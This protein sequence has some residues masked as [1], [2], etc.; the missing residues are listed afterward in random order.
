MTPDGIVVVGGGIAGHS[1][2]EAIRERDADIPLTL[3]CGEPRLPYDRV[4][5]SELLVSGR[6]SDSLELRPVDWYEDHSVR[7]VLGRGATQIETSR[8]RV[9]LT[10]GEILPYDSLVVAT[11]SQ[12]LMPP[13]PGLHLPGVVSFRGPSDCEAIRG[14]AAAG[15]GRVAVIGGGLL[16]LEAAYGVASQGCPV[17]VIHLMDRLMERQLDDAAA[18]LLRPAMER[19]GV[20]VLLERETERVLGDER[21]RGLRFVDGSE[22]EAGLIVV[23]IG[24]HP[25]TSVAR[26]AGIEVA[27]GITVDDEMRTSAPSVWAV[28]ECAEHRGVVY[29][30]VA[31][32]RE[33]AEAAADSIVG[34]Q[35]RHAYQGSLQWAR[36]KVMGV[37]VVSIGRPEGAVQAVTTDASGP[38][39][40]KL[41]V[42]D[43]RA[44]GAIL[45]GDVRG[46]DDLLEAIRGAEQIVDPLP[47][48]AAAAEVTAAELPDGAQ[49]CNCN[50]VRK[51]DVLSA[52]RDLGCATAR[53]VMARTRAGTG[54]GS[55]KATVKELVCA[56]TG[57]VAE[58]PTY[59]CPCRRQTR[60]QLA[61][62]IREHELTAVSE[63]AAG[64]GTG[65]EC[66]TCKPALAYLVSEINANRHREQRE[67]RFINDRVH[68][69]IQKD[70]TFSVVPRMYGGVTT[71]DQLRRIADAAER[72]GA[73]MVK[74]TGGQRIDLLGVRKRDLPDIWRD[75]GMP[76]GHAYA[77]AV[78]TVKSCVGSDFCRFGLADSI[79]LAVALEKEWEGL[80]TPAKVKSGVSGC[81][82]NCAEATVK[83]IGVVAVEG[84]WQIRV[85]GAAGATVREAD[86]LACVQSV[87]EVM[88]ITTA[89]LQYYRENG[90]YKERLYD[91]VPRVGLERIRAVVLD[92]DE[93]AALRE[94]FR[95]AKSAVRD[96]WLERDDLYHQRQFRELDEPAKNA[97]SVALV[98]PPEDGE[99]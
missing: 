30:L 76:S 96:P 55:C 32:I 21:V 87:E 88:R 81:P 93:G 91:F 78:R 61:A 50:G 18:A 19:L 72:Y 20:E 85:G 68:A 47:R 75:V 56:A 45:L 65:R 31:P 25:E 5:L 66:G 27:R 80:S 37:D 86:L 41:V 60:E 6:S 17:T 48:L 71:P 16:G 1:T 4:R 94:R 8:R 53:E 62:T 29:G 42:E 39:Y 98:G 28:G 36:L 57:G 67:A 64:C 51:I 58:E 15:V 3:V 35:R 33:Q 7:L 82:R 73:R 26:E 54:C 84:G 95:I 92:E 43:G 74:V 14:A 34:R 63:V 22:V 52:V 2:C 38:T 11:G 49:I 23:S 79:A 77:K 10:N 13:I 89:L 59:L 40:R 24:I 70:G 99:R 46:S 44:R 90:E 69:N 83:D 9:E 12:P 97:P